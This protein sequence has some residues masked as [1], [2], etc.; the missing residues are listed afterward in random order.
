MSDE[1][2]QAFLE[3]A[4]NDQTL[5]EKLKTAPDPASVIEIAKDA[6]YIFSVE[7][8]DNLSIEISDDE[9]E[10]ASGGQKPGV[11]TWG[12]VNTIWK[13]LET[14]GR[15]CDM[16]VKHD[17]SLM[18]VIGDVNDD[19]AEMAQAVRNLKNDCS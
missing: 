13:F 10:S 12:T 5:L 8:L 3:N 19:L 2:L 4:K 18:T 17:V 16:R 9:L 14:W 15:L 1:Q 11:N 7:N 6:G